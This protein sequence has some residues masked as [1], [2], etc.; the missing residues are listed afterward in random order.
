MTTKKINKLHMYLAVE[1]ICDESPTAWG[2]L[3]AWADAYA[4][5]QTRVTNIQNLSKIQSQDN[6]GIAAD[7][8][9]ARQTMATLALPVAK[10]VHAYALKAKNLTLANTV[11]FSM[12]DLMHARDVQS[13]ERCETIYD[14]ATANLAALTDYKVTA[15]QLTT[16]DNA[17]DAYNL[18][19]SKPRD[20]RA[21]TR[22]VTHNLKDEFAAADADLVQLDDLL[23]Q[24]TDAKFVSDFT[25]ARIIVD[26]AASHD[27]PTPP[28]P[29]TAP[30]AK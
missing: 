11:D 29:P 20:S 6:T 15:A 16:L 1:D 19:I 18:L 17:I 3:P 13:A 9:A 7:K 23:G 5:F 8:E 21:Q 24:L 27:S 25:N 10:A 26:T 2:S 22:T 30:P 12:S 4:D 28:T 14:S